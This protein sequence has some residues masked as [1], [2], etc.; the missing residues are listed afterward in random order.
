MNVPR[1][2]PVAR[3]GSPFGRGRLLAAVLAVICALPA[4]WHG[5]A[6]AAASGEGAYA[7]L[8]R[9][10]ARFSLGRRGSAATAPPLVFGIYPGGA[11][12][13]VGPS[14]RTRPED[15][16]LRM[17]SLERLRGGRRPFVLHLYDSFTRRAD[18]AAVPDG[19][20][21][22]I[23]GYTRRGFQVEVVL[24]YRPADPGGDVEGFVE[25]V[26]SR[27]RQFGPDRGVTNLQVT[28][29]A[30]ITG[31]PNA[32]DGAYPGV[33][34]ALV[35]GVVAAKDEAHRGGFSQIVVGFN[36]AYERGPR[37]R[38]FW[39]ALGDA[40]GPAF[41]RA[42][43][44]VGLDAY[45]GTWGPPLRNRRL[46]AGAR[47]ATLD[48]LRLLRTTYLPLAHLDDVALH[49][50]EAG[51]PTG[52]G[53]A[54]RKQV[55]VLSAVARAVSDHRATL[56]VTDFRW[57]DLRD[58]DSSSASFESRY[59]LVRDDYRPKRGFGAYRRIIASLG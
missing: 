43:D 58:A 49:V 37:E 40:G 53:R 36:W 12:G 34:D 6:P 16:S 3:A 41:A 45:P 27:V 13:T 5:S 52:P 18:A 32:A 4:A 46:G 44:W 14:G 56:G 31:A 24:A 7:A 47:A 8:V 55:A 33:R 48:A 19:L 10:G 26:R 35:H 22:D 29:E 42:V 25:F 9:D 20:A 54:E 57:F 51:Y 39:S 2:S 28:N 17:A 23:A 59:G 50:S 21:S 11:A 38:S 1:R 15:P 30:N